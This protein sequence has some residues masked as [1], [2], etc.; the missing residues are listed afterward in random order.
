[1]KAILETYNIKHLNLR[2]IEIP[3]EER[4]KGTENVFEEIMAE[5]F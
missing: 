5:N 3:E 2:I 1:M 4:E